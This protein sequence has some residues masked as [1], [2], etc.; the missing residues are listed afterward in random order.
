[1]ECDVGDSFYFDYEPN[2]IRSYSIQFE[3]KWKYIFWCVQ[4]VT[5]VSNEKPVIGFFFY[6]GMHYS[7]FRPHE[8]SLLFSDF[9]L[10][11]ISLL[12][13]DFRSPEISLLFS[14]LRSLEISIY[15]FYFR[16]DEISLLFYDFRSPEISL[17]FSNFRSSEISLLFSVWLDSKRSSV[18]YQIDRK[19]VRIPREWYKTEAFSPDQLTDVVRFFYAS[20]LAILYV[21][22]LGWR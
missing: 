21:I 14:D 6:S 5:H 18:W 3:R 15:F 13:S 4:S 7:D 2:R 22:L 8:I 10:P 19:G 17:V 11:E 9:R 20:W 16:S 1:M 12:F